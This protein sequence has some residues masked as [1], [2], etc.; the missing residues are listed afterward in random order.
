MKRSPPTLARFSAWPP[1]SGNPDLLCRCLSQPDLPVFGIYITRAALACAG[2]MIRAS[3]TGAVSGTWVIASSPTATAPI[4]YQAGASGL[5][6][7]CVSHATT[8]W[9]EPPN[10]EVATA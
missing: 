8:N 1:S 4:M 5:P 10:T 9:V 6:V 3:F 7:S 2:G